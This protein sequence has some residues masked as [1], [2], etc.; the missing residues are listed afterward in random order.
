M[1]KNSF[2]QH[3]I[4]V[5][6]AT[7]KLMDLIQQTSITA[8]LNDL[9]LLNFSEYLDDNALFQVC[10][11]LKMTLQTHAEITSENSIPSKRN[12]TLL[13]HALEGI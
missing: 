8:F 13:R 9:S 10:I 7:S 6:S 3:N 12:G 5:I 11:R 2:K 4:M 1:C